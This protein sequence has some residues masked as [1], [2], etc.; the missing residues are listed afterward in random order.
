MDKAEAADN[1]VDD[2]GTRLPEA[3]SRRQAL[4]VKLDE[5]AKRL[6]EEAGKAHDERD[7]SP[8]KADK[9]INLTD[10]DS[11]IMRKPPWMRT[12]RCWSW[13]RMCYPP[14]MTGRVLRLC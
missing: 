11:A 8:V 10:P 6:Q 3:L 2:D 1:A 7:P 14:R 13:Q 9:Q 4:K 5:A 12:G